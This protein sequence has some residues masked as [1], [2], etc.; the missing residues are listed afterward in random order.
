MSLVCLI[1]DVFAQKNLDSLTLTKAWRTEGPTDRRKNELSLK[2]NQVSKKCHKVS[3]FTAL[4]II[5][6][7]IHFLVSNLACV[8]S[9]TL[10]IDSEGARFWKPTSYWEIL[11]NNMTYSIEHNIEINWFITAIIDEQGYFDYLNPL[12]GVL[13]WKIVPFAVKCC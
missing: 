9:L 11:P 5:L 4:S 6:K 1:C 2:K 3:W 10:Q 13:F 8:D 7:V 12:K